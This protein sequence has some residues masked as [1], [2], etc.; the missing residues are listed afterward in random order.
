M[1]PLKCI[2]WTRIKKDKEAMFTSPSILISQNWLTIP[3]SKIGQ[4]IN[5]RTVLFIEAN[6][7]VSTEKVTAFRSGLTAQSI[8]DTGKTTWPTVKD[9]STMLMAMSMRVTG[10]KT[11]HMALEYTPIL[12]EQN[13]RANGKKMHKME[14]VKKL[15]LTAQFLKA[16][17]RK[18]RSMAKGIIFGV[19][20]LLSM[21][22]GG[23]I[24]FMDMV[25][26]NGLTVESIK[27]IGKITICME[28]V[29]ILG[30]TAE[31]T[32]E[33]ITMIRSTDMESTNGQ[34]EGNTMDSGLRASNTEKASMCC[35]QVS[36][37]KASGK[38]VTE[39]NGH[40]RKQK[41]SELKP[42]KYIF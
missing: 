28:R 19:M 34:M 6:G 39:S 17:T 42:V 16:Y 36:K 25:L 40:P 10:P 33:T 12:T 22:N 14:L 32:K 30:L 37:E 15:G 31:V 27:E 29:F 3:A 35:P 1:T 18:V 26:T 7:K 41:S 38:E 11:R 21:V 8:W 9:Y 24:I 20:N 13:T 5:S 4:S 2:I 23:T